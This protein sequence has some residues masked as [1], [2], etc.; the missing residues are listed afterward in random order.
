MILPTIHLN[1]TSRETLSQEYQTAWRAARKA[2][3]ALAETTCHARDYYVHPQDGAFSEAQL[4]RV[5]NLQMLDHVINYLEDHV[6]H[7]M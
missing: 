4:E 6:M 3:E 2:R 1:G 5:K 7:L